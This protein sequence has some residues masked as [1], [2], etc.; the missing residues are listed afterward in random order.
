MISVAPEFAEHGVAVTL[1]I[2]A[3][4]VTVSVS[5]P[6]LSDALSQAVAKIEQ[7]DKSLMSAVT[8]TR[9]AYKALGKDPSRYRPAADALIRRSANGKPLASINNIIDINNLISLQSGHSIGSYDADK[10]KPPF[11]LRTGH[12]GES[13]DGIGRGPINLEKL[14]ILADAHAAFGSPTSDSERSKVTETTRNLLMVVYGLNHA[15]DCLD[16]LARLLIEHASAD[17][18]SVIPCG[19]GQSL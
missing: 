6:A 4:R 15:V 11:T 13:Y 8:A 18:L 16:D 2:I 5:S 17:D 12:V 14:I 10:L 9:R 1:G 3:C 7:S 19:T